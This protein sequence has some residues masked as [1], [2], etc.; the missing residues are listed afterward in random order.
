MAAVFMKQ[1]SGTYASVGIAA[2]EI[3]I[4]FSWRLSNSWREYLAD[5]QIR[6]VNIWRKCDFTVVYS[7]ELWYIE[8]WLV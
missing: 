6:G 3:S 8:M 7:V 5:F 2:S 1:S 4:A